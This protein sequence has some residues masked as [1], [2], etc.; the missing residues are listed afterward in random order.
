VRCGDD[1]VVRAVVWSALGNEHLTGQSRPFKTRFR[2]LKPRSFVKTFFEHHTARAPGGARGGDARK[3]GG[4]S[5]NFVRIF[6]LYIFFFYGFL[7]GIR[8]V[9][10]G[11]RV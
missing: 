11:F 9:G 5:S 6:F 7:K 3:E 1:D 10:L 8:V 4:E 2:V